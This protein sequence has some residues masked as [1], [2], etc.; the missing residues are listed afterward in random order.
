MRVG[1]VTSSGPVPSRVSGA[2][3]RARAEAPRSESV[4][5]RLSPDEA[6]VVGEAAA[7]AGLSAGA[8]VGDTAVDR[9]RAEAARAD[10]DEVGGVGTTG[11]SSWRELVAALV[12]LRAEAAAVRRVRVVEPKSVVPGGELLVDQSCFGAPGRVVGG[13][14]AEVLRRI[15]MV[16]AA[17]V[18]ATSSVARRRSL[19][20]DAER[21]GQS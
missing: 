17:A 12:A 20:T 18:E 7:R 21:S 10:A 1:L 2:R 4:W 15:D 8:W 16:T 13:D 9:A 19:P 5:V 6:A 11:P 3:R 14:V